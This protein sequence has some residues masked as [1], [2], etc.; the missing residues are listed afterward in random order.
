MVLHLEKGELKEIAIS[1]F[2]IS[3]ALA[4]AG[5]GLG[6]LVGYPDVL[7]L[8]YYLLITVGSG[9]ILH[10]LSHKFVAIYYGARARFRMWVSGLGMMM[11]LSVLGMVFAAPGAVY[12]YTLPGDSVRITKR[13]NGI[14]SLSGPLTNIALMFVF[15]FLGMFAPVYFYPSKFDYEP[16]GFVNNNIWF[17]GSWINFIL[18]LFNLLPVFPLDGSKIFHWN[19][20]V[21]LFVVALLLLI[22]LFILPLAY[23]V[24]VLI[25][26]LV[27]VAISR[28][29]FFRRN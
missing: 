6:V 3:L 2:A 27:M 22:G 19:F 4:I 13:E 5:G 16:L 20:L 21:W 10:E 24:M 18:A 14:I 1:V 9:F 28:L 15:L 26:M 11:V 17:F 12:I 7:L 25:F 23:L 29:L 8:L